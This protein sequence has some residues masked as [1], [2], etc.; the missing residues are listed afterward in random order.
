MPNH[1]AAL[2][3][4]QSTDASA[5]T[6][7][8][9]GAVLALTALAAALRFFHLEQWSWS[10]AEATTWRA[11]TEPADSLFASSRGVA[12]LGYLAL[13]E[14]C[15]LHLLPTH[16]EGWLRLPFAFAGV[17]AVPLLV[18]A[19]RPWLGAG[20]AL[21]AGLLLA[22]HPL[23]VV[24]SQSALP[25]GFALA[26][27]LAAAVAAGDRRRVL[28]G[29]ALLAAC[30]CDAIAWTFAA[31]LLA[32]LLPP[33][34][35]TWVAR[36]ATVAAAAAAPCTLGALSLPLL[37]VA[38]LG[39]LHERRDALR[40]CTAVPLAGASLAVL[41]GGAHRE[42]LLVA[43][44]PGLAIFAA[45]GAQ[46]VFAAAR[47]TL[48]GSA[49]AIAAGGALAGAV[50]VVALAVQ[51]SLALTVFH[52]WRPRWRGA[53]EAVWSA[54]GPAGE[55]VLAAGSGADSLL[56]YLRPNHWRDPAVDPY[57]ERAVVPFAPADA[58]AGLASLAARPEPCVLL[59]LCSD[60]V[61]R[62][63][64]AARA[65]LARGFAIAQ[66]DAS[67]GPHGDETIYVYR[68]IAPH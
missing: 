8:Q 34:G 45:V 43:A 46:R 40:L 66:V 10:E 25:V 29:T 12:P 11:L 9:T 26:L 37:A 14:L 41:A 39:A 5:W 63:D 59:V 31:A 52:G 28:A 18:L 2:A 47:A 61:E 19:A 13:R 15:G 49:R 44:L 60:E 57:P 65:E 67:P 33:R 30:L 36:A 23:H 53:E 27:V 32:L 54:A 17:V 35:R 38:A 55:F 16:G 1:V 4:S 7:T 24:V 56:C 21:F 3:A 6:R 51:S 58:A 48:R 64:A 20:G 42:A 50:L 62:F 68:R 22:V